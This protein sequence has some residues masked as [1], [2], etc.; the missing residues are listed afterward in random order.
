MHIFHFANGTRLEQENFQVILVMINYIHYKMNFL[1]W[2]KKYAPIWQTQ[3]FI[4][5]ILVT[6]TIV[7]C[8]YY[9][10]W[11]FEFIQ[12]EKGSLLLFTETLLQ[13]LFYSLKML[14]SRK[15]NLNLKFCPNKF[16]NFCIK[17]SITEC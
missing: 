1:F 9:N 7:L 16:L 5:V 4:F 6:R 12:L 2:G 13:I 14:I 17:K 11:I 3:E 15:K 10:S 8:F